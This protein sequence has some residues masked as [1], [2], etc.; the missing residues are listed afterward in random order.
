MNGFDFSE[1]DML[2]A[3]LGKA[4]NNVGPF[5]AKAVEVTARRVKDAA[6]KRVA[7]RKMMKQAASAI[8]YE[9]KGFRGF[10]A[11]VFDAEIGYNKA[12]GPGRIGNLVEF[13]APAAREVVLIVKK[14]GVQWM[15]KPGGRVKPLAPGRE[16]QTALHENEGDFQKGLEIAVNDALREA[17][18]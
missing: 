18:L 6:R 14:T 15:P 11:T 3:D 9:L 4:A 1:L 7:G 8:D 17:N 10:G 13:G 2:A 16:L 5:T 12:K